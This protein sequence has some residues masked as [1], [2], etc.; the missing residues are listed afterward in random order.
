MARHQRTLTVDIGSTGLRVAEFEYPP[1]GGIVMQAFEYVEYSEHLTDT[2][3]GLVVSTALQ[4]GLGSG[5]FTATNRCAVCIS[6]QAAFM[7]F[8][9]L[10]PVSEEESRIQQIVEYEARQNVPFPIDEVIWDYQLIS[11]DDEELEVM[12]VVVKNE[13]VESVIHGVTAAGA[14][15]VL[16]DFAPAALYN[17]ARANHVGDN[18]C[19]MVLNIGGRSSSLLFIEGNH[20]FVRTIPI[21]GYTITQ[22]IAKE[23][24]ITAEEAEILKKRHG[25]VALGGA[26]EEPESEVAA[27]IS[28]IVRNVMTRLH[29]EINRSINVYRTQQKGNKPT[30]LYLSGG[31]S[32]MAFTN[33][34]FQEKLRMEVNYLNPFKIVSLGEGV[35][36][37]QLQDVA[38]MFPET[39]GMALRHSVECPVEVSLVPES[40]KI[41]QKFSRKKPYIIASILVLAAT[42]GVFVAVNFRKVKL[43]RETAHK[44][45]SQVARLQRIRNDLKKA[46]AG[47]D[48]AVESYGIINGIMMQRYPWG[49]FY[50]ALQMNKPQ[51]VWF[52]SITPMVKGPTEEKKTEEPAPT[53]IFGKAQPKAANRTAAAAVVEGEAYQW[54]HLVGHTISIPGRKLFTEDQIAHFNARAKEI[55]AAGGTPPPCRPERYD[56]VENVVPE[57][58]AELPEL[59]V[60][61]LSSAEFVEPDGVRIVR[62]EPERGWKNHTEFELHVKLSAPIRIKW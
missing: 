34:F 41:R 14:H 58:V 59:L 36:I 5:K 29:G 12:F 53:N 13:I 54:F 55:T 30:I 45:E 18:E 19:A 8:V 51:D 2:N 24:G 56:S 26:Y 39:V 52:D 46:L 17:V 3:R 48:K 16:V 6:G 4:K 9:K 20:L 10:P 49:D 15:P 40:V 32:T 1:S 38:H 11:G 22:Q 33:E 57:D 25:F 27:T 43:Y 37:K 47:Q 21:A 62:F 42:L 23:F 60:R 28:K 31:S 44:R 35:D 61:I 7:R 50:N